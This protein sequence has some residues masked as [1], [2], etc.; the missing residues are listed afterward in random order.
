MTE[1][2][3]ILIT[4]GAQRIGL[5]CAQ[6]LVEDGYRVIITCRQARP[7]WQ[8][9]PLRG[10]EGLVADFSSVEGIRR[11][12]DT[13]V[14]RRVRVRA[15]SHNASVWDNGDQGAGARPQV[16]RARQRA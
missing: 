8:D 12:I 11:L 13:L 3:P 4:G 2:P 6:R 7:E 16:C 5:H 15:L 9:H 1:K 14:E 10:I